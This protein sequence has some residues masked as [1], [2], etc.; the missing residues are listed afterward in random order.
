VCEQNR[1][2]FS[3]WNLEAFILDELLRSIN[4]EK[5]TVFINVPDI[6]GV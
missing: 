1:F 5:V 6:A 4:D 3:G 2:K